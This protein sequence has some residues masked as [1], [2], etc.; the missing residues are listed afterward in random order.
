M[1][2]DASVDDEFVHAEGEQRGEV[3][4]VTTAAT[5]TNPIL[6]AASWLGEIHRK[7]VAGGERCFADL[8]NGV[9]KRYS[10]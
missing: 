10:V 4:V 3:I 8:A 5:L 2:A 6:R 9:A 1:V 7:L